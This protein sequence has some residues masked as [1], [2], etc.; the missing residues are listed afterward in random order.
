M[1][2]PLILSG[3]NK[4]FFSALPNFTSPVRL[5]PIPSSRFFFL[6][7]FPNS[8]LPSI[9]TDSTTGSTY[10][11]AKSAL[12]IETRCVITRASFW[13]ISVKLRERKTS[14]NHITFLYPGKERSW[15]ARDGGRRG[16][17][18]GAAGRRRLSRA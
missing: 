3:S 11:R 1:L 17:L 10:F 8:D 2:N 18:D 9:I 4:S 12:I 6:L 7:N 14:E 13:K 15:L 5:R 16:R